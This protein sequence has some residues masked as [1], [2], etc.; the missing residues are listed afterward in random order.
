MKKKEARDMWFLNACI[1]AGLSCVYVCVWA[2]QRGVE[3]IDNAKRATHVQFLGSH[4]S[5]KSRSKE[6]KSPKILRYFFKKKKLFSCFTCKS[7]GYSGLQVQNSN[8]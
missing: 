2:G 6:A 3:S 5:V 8:E 1:Y 7:L 4:A